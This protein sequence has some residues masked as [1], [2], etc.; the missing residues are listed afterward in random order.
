MVIGFRDV[1]QQDQYSSTFPRLERYDIPAS[2][3]LLA[4]LLPS[5]LP[6]F[7]LITNGIC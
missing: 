1:K 4:H 7:F 6:C 3:A 2:F 5:L